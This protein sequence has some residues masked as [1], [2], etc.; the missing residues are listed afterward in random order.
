MKIEAVI[1]YST[2]D[3]RFFHRCVQ[4]LLEC[5]IPVHVITYTHMWNGTPESVDLLEKSHGLFKDNQMYNHYQVDWAP[6]KSP[7]HWERLGRNL[8][9]DNVSQD[10]DYILYIDTDEIV[11]VPKFREFIESGIYT[12]YNSIRL[13]TYWYF[14]E[15][16]Y[17][18]VQKESNVVMC[19]AS[20][21]RNIRN[22]YGRNGYFSVGNT[23]VLH[24]DTP[25]VH[26]F[27][28]VRTKEEMLNKVKN[29]GHAGERNW[30]ASIEKEFSGPFTG[31]DFVHGYQYTTVENLFN[32]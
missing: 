20:L 17:R 30:V 13:G 15:P 24:T 19:K 12:K 11:E 10:C 7:W 18:A 26:H 25:L 1:P 2:N 6:G 4:N 16:I 3:Y 8:G 9:T 32:L 31:T 23:A 28:W 21:A 22:S 27:S 29:W 5:E 14:R